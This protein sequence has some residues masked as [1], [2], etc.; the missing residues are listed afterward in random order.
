M[1]SKRNSYLSEVLSFPLRQA[2]STFFCDSYSLSMYESICRSIFL[3]VRWSIYLFI[4]PFMTWFF[5]LSM[6]LYINLSISLTFPHSSF[7]FHLQEFLGGLIFLPFQMSPRISIRGY[8]RRSVRPSV[9]N[10][11]VKSGEM[12]HLQR[13]KYGETHLI[14]SM[15]APASLRQDMSVGRSVHQNE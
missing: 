12:K 10:A 9:R 2:L 5:Y 3:Y 7:P 8:F 11:F 15:C 1:I 6:Y 4:Y 14:C 13:K